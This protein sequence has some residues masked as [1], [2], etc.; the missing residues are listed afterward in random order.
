MWCT[1]RPLLRV[2]G[3]RIGMPS[4]KL[5]T[6]CNPCRPAGDPRA[7][8]PMPIPDC[9][10]SI[11][12]SA[13][14]SVCLRKCQNP[15]HRIR[16]VRGRDRDVADQIRVDA[17]CGEG[18]AEGNFGLIIISKPNIDLS[19]LQLIVFTWRNQMI[20]LYNAGTVVVG[21]LR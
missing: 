14:A 10:A 2:S 1:Y 15:S 12:C 20:I 5:R 19:H 17:F 18:E 11:S 8:H 3:R 16:S 6:A 13:P 9:A 21:P 4:L 7:V